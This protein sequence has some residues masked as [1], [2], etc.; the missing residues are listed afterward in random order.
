MTTSSKIW[1]FHFAIFR[2]LL[3]FDKKKIAIQFLINKNAREGNEMNFFTNK[4]ATAKCLSSLYSDD[5]QCRI[6]N[7]RSLK[8]ILLLAFTFFAY[9]VYAQPVITTFAPQSGPAGTVVTITGSGFSLAPSLNKVFF[10]AAPAYVTASTNTSLTVEVPPGANYGYIS[11]TNI[12]N[13]L[14]VYSSI[15][16]N[17]TFPGGCKPEFELKRDFTTDSIPYSVCIGDLDGD[18]RSDMAIANHGSNTVSVFPNTSNADVISFAAKVDFVTGLSPK[19][20]NFGDIDGDSR[21]DM[22]VT[23]SGDNSVSV[24]R[25][26]SSLGNISFSAKVDFGTGASPWSVSIG[27]LNGDGKPDLAVANRVSWTVSVLRNTSTSGVVSFLSKVDFTTGSSPYSVSIGDL[28]GDGK[29]DLATANSGSN[30]ASVFKNTSTSGAVSFAAKV[31]FNAGSGPI[32][33][34][35]GDIDGDGKLDL[36]VANN[37]SNNA[38]VFRNTST[39]GIINAGSF[40]ARVDFAA[41]GAPQTVSIG[42][43]DGDGKPDLA[44]ANFTG[45]SVS[46]LRNASVPGTVTFTGKVDL[47]TAG[48]ASSLSIGDFD[49]YGKPEVVATNYNSKT[50]SLFRNIATPSVL[51]TSVSGNGNPI[52]NG[53]VIP[54]LANHTDFGNVLIGGNL[55]RTYTIQNSST[56]S[57]RVDSIKI[58]G[59]DQALFTPGSITPA[60]KIAPGA[61]KTF[62]VTCTPLATGLKSAS[63]NIYSNINSGTSCLLQQTYTF[64]V[65]A[66]GGS[67]PVIVSFSPQSGPVGG[68]VT[69]TGGGFDTT[70][71]NNI[72]FFG[73]A[74]AS[75]SA[76]TDTSL[77]VTTPAGAN[78]QYI[79]VTN[80]GSNLTGYSS[81]PFI[82][83]FPGG[84]KTEFATRVNFSTGGTPYSVS[85]GDLDKDGKSDL[86]VANYG[87]NTVSV[88]RNTS[89]TGGVSFAAK[90]DFG[91]GSSPKSVSIGDIDGDG[92]PDLVVTNSGASNSVSVFRNTSTPGVINAGS[93]AAKIDF[94][95]GSSPWS[96][97]VGDLNADGKPDLAVANRVSNTV[98]V[99]RNTST[100]GIVSFL[101]RV[102]FATGSSPYSVSI[103]D[104]DRDGKPDMAVASN[105]SNI[106]S[107]YQN[108]STSGA[109]SF[110]AKVDFNAGSGPISVSIGDIDGDGKLDLAVANNSSNNASV[111][112]NTSTPGIINAGSFAARVDFA[113]GGA[114]QIISIGDI[115]GDSK[116]DL[117]VANFS[118]SSVSVL[119]NTSV[120]GTVSFSAKVDL[121][122]AG[123]ASSV[124]IGDFD[125]TGKPEVVASNYNT[126]NLSVFRNLSTPAALQT[127]ASGNGNPITN[128]SV[129]PSLTNHTS[130]GDVILG[131]NLIRTY[132]FQNTSTDSLSVD[133]IKMSGTDSVS[134]I[135]GS[136]TPAGKMAPGS[137]KTF[138]VTCT[139]LT[140]GLKTA[141]VN[142]YSNINSGTSCL[143]QQTYTF[144]VQATGTVPVQAEVLNF[145]GIND[146]VALPNTLPTS[147]T[148][149][150]TTE[151]TIEY[152]FKGTSLQSAVR[153]QNGSGYIVAGWNGLHIISS[154]GGTGAGIS[155]GAAATDGNWHH[156]AFTW[157]KNTVNGFR[158]YLDGALV[159]Q[160]NS[161][162]VNLPVVTSGGYLGAYNGASEWMNGTLDEV[163]I[164]KRQLS[165]TEI[166]ANRFLEIIS[167][168]ALLASYHFNQGIAGGNNTGITT[169]TD[170]TS[171]NYTST[172]NNFTLNGPASNFVG[173]GP[174]LTPQ[175]TTINIS[176]IPEGLYDAGTD[177]LRLRDTVEA[178]LHSNVSPYGVVDSAVAVIDSVTFTGSFIFSNASSG[179]YY[180]RVNHRNS[181]E[182]WSKTGGETFV[183]GTTMSYNFTSA[184]QA[185]G[186]NMIQV[187]ASPVRFGVFSGDV[188]QDRT[189]DATDVSTVDND[190]NNYVSGYVITD[191]T[192]DNFVDGTDFAIADNN[193]ANYVSA[194]T[195]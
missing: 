151:F 85:I 54:S 195:P 150:S 136:I 3:N 79:S 90:V 58:S 134:F 119:R 6:I 145:D 88:F 159:A 180:I 39:P 30:T 187:D 155:V 129:T 75:V 7:A 153:I 127:S 5:S 53:S 135:P 132:T 18:S 57:L 78:F 31:D 185:F 164:W 65:K 62:T 71:S 72:V 168:T 123:Q 83:T 99:F 96:V 55:I 10:G 25:N 131:G 178:Y 35:I 108:T 68:T 12:E 84:C 100:S 26:T 8:A 109:V 9:G 117:A 36:A 186:N 107:A 45:N 175:S 130:F 160:R 181:I 174:A 115:D 106:V 193:A 182:T 173:S 48:Q 59:T 149:A 24:F 120:T 124:I 121:G 19:S 157:K 184:S 179:T 56:D 23:N 189:V 114:P 2:D 69:I 177:R 147:F 40:A 42:D 28:D 22:I 161:A 21:L 52:T 11:V 158:S 70:A 77:T 167:G 142:I 94:G 103:G 172:L 34:S 44:V 118:G 16:F 171:N 13:H 73:A 146:H 148:G 169:L 111:F 162:N 51:Q 194:I 86:A 50:F 112:R 27:D 41:G 63:V 64:A 98:S 82:V 143:I 74:L 183:Q 110:A 141:T 154:D 14:T 32:S 188:N 61:S 140:T 87:S 20:V 144:A 4:S 80:L 66:T 166:S 192:G 33:V 122:S 76:S 113:A 101:S 137:S 29:P 163:R 104:L 92:K 89:T 95:T 133:S 152:W 139:P 105:G 47:T 102:D 15:P 116:P 156:I 93:F 67:L 43:I 126:N 125:G 97:S 170:A 46:V 37:S 81:M 49:N 38:S 165:Q 190:A 176:L 17:L 91:T 1:L 128:G 191:L 60:G 138:T